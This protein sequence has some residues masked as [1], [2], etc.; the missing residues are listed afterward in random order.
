MKQAEFLQ[1]MRAIFATEDV[2]LLCSEFFTL[3]PQYVDLERSGQEAAPRLPHVAHHLQQCPEC[4]EVY[5]ALL[6]ATRPDDDHR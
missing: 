3:L 5:Q 6:R 4:A 1:L 2:E